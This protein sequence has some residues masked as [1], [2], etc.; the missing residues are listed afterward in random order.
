MAMWLW[1]L[2]LIP[3]VDQAVKIWLRRA[4]GTH[5]VRLGTVI[6]LQIVSTHVW[7][8]RIGRRSSLVRIWGMWVISAVFLIGL[9]AAIPASRLFVV[10]LLAGSLSHAIETTWRGTVCDYICSRW[11]PAF[12]LADVAITIGA[13]GVVARTSM[14]LL[15]RS[16]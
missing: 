4:L 9:S 8:Q 5:T 10:L 12:N 13:I 15:S 2:L 14:A 3:V 11:W 6:T 1:A 16:A 7:W